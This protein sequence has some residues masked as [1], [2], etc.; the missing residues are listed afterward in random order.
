MKLL[1][2]LLTINVA[3]AT[4]Y[5]TLGVSRDASQD[6]IKKAYRRLALKWHP[7]KRPND[8]Q[9][10][11]KFKEVS[12][13]YEVLGDTRKRN[14]YDQTGHNP[15]AGSFPQPQGGFQPGWQPGGF[16]FQP[17]FSDPFDIFSRAFGDSRFR[18]PAPKKEIVIHKVWCTLEELHCGCRKEIRLRNNVI[19]RLRSAHRTG[20]LQQILK[21]FLMRSLLVQNWIASVGEVIV[22][23]NRLPKAVNGTFAFDVKPGWRQGTKISF[24]DPDDP[25][26]KVQFEIHEY[27]HPLLERR[28]YDLWWQRNLSRRELQ[29][30]VKLRL[31]TLDQQKMFIRIRP[32]EVTRDFVKCLPGKGMPIK[33]GPARG[34]YWIKFS[35]PGSSK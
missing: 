26:R 31:P 35:C 13:A 33:G 6:E 16:Q 22:Q 4:Y 5:R 29:R 27:A 25:N 11:V 10:S 30:G 28:R 12:E 17:G 3:V 2:L 8:D 19:S 18:A 9:A 1:S 7:D 23:L 14:I 34:N 24:N 21:G 20:V 15:S 32:N